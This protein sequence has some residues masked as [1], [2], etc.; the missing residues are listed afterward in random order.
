MANL[1]SVTRMVLSLALAGVQPLSQGFF[2][3]YL[4]CVVSDLLDGY[5][6]RTTHT[7]SKLG[8]KLD[9]AA[10]LTLFAVLLLILYPV[11]R[12]PGYILVWLLAIGSIR[13]ISLL[14][15]FIKF[16]TFAILH[17]YGNKITGLA[18]AAF[19]LSLVAGP[20]EELLVLLCGIA[21]ASALEELWIHL[22]ANEL[23]TDRKS[24]FE[25]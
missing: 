10:D 18:L 3:L 20:P 2:V 16:K 17:T 12:P 7:T 4:I 21:S 19:P 15:V 23:R 14:V 9:S 8:E 22:S 25:K 11:L 5:V 24:W 13:V 1:I 6:A